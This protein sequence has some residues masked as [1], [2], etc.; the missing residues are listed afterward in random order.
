MRR[1]IHLL[2]YEGRR[3]LAPV[4]AQYLTA[5]YQK[6]P[7]DRLVPVVDS[8]VPVPLHEQR[9]LERGFNQSED[10]ARSF[11]QDS[12]LPLKTS[13]L[14]RVIATVP[15]VG[16]DTVSRQANVSG[17]FAASR[18]VD[19]RTILLIDDVYT[20]GA[21]LA[22][23]GQALANAGALAVYGLALAVPGLERGSYT[24]HGVGGAGQLSED[25]LPGIPVDN[26]S[27]RA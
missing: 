19:G 22:A 27:D 13:A 26:D 8:V 7:W 25:F 3:D 4:L 10:L 14:R 24:A 11:C 1:A 6:P 2:K 20:T 16:L 15:Q 12:N 21:T 17:A 9:L 18:C 5:A 23:C